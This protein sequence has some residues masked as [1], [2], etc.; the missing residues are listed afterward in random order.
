MLVDWFGDPLGVRITS[1]SFMEWINEDNLKEFECGIFT[2]PVT[3]QDSRSPT[4]VPSSPLS[5]RLKASDKLQ[6]VNAMMG[7]LATVH[8]LRNRVSAATMVHTNPIYDITL[9]GLV[10][11]PAH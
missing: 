3:I 5:N 9:L 4:V 8:T 2:N 1:N 6:L 11:Q 7:R 10:S